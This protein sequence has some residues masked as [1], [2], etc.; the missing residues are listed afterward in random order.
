MDFGI[1]QPSLRRWLPRALSRQGGPTGLIA[2]A[3]EGFELPESR[4]VLAILDGIAITGRPFFRVDAL[5]NSAAPLRLCGSRSPRRQRN[6][7]VV[8][9]VVGA[10][11][12]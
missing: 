4:A 12:S 9:I 3:C 2:E 11:T 8:G 5:S 6:D 7:Q 1:N 10:T